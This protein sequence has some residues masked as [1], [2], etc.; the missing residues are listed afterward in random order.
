MYVRTVPLLSPVSWHHFVC[1]VRTVYAAKMHCAGIRGTPS[2]KSA[3]ALALWSRFNA[4]ISLIFMLHVYCVQYLQLGGRER[5]AAAF[6]GG[7]Y[8]SCLEPSGQEGCRLARLST[9]MKQ[10]QYIAE[11][12][13]TANRVR[14]QHPGI[15]DLF[16][17]PPLPRSHHRPRRSRRSRFV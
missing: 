16:T 5:G 1:I 15:R 7:T 4:P 9:N 14:E 10:W 11:A 17:C 2:C 8:C 12:L 13:C 3:Y 6:S